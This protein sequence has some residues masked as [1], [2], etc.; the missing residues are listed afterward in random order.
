MKLRARRRRQSPYHRDFGALPMETQE[1]FF[2][3]VRESVKARREGR[4]VEPEGLTVSRQPRR[5]P[6]PANQGTLAAIKAAKAGQV[7]P[8]KPKDL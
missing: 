7:S 4:R 2:E 1:Q 3:R 8:V 5:Q 6:S